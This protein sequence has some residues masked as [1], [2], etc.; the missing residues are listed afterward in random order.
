MNT[1]STQTPE[2]L[3]SPLCSPGVIGWWGL[4]HKDGWW[5]GTSKGANTYHDREF[6]RLALTILWQREGGKAL[7]YKIERF[8][9]ANIIDGDFTPRKSAEDAIKEYE[10][11][12]S[13][14]AQDNRNNQR[15]PRRLRKVVD[16]V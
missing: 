1:E 5:A 11:N 8:T 14:P 9:G 3:E 10:E 7:D 4:R 13:T 15:R 16:N 2:S 12:A 6:A